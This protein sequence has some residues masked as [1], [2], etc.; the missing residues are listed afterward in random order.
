MMQNPKKFQKPD[1]QGEEEPIFAFDVPF[2]G[3]IVFDDA[4]PDVVE[5]SIIDNYENDELIPCSRISDPDDPYFKQLQATRPPQFID[6][7][8][9]CIILPIR[10]TKVFRA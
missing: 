4:D 6:K 10:Y 5:N 2:G 8:I 1:D 9:R 7:N 3:L